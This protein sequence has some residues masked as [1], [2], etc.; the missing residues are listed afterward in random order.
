MPTVDKKHF[1][2]TKKGI[3]KAKDY[4]KKTGKKLETQYEGVFSNIA[5][6]KSEIKR[7]KLEYEKA[8]SEY[9]A[10]MAGQGR[11]SEYAAARKVKQ[12]WLSVKEV[13]K[14]MAVA[15]KPL[16][17]MVEQ[18]VV[19]TEATWEYSYELESD[20][21]DDGDYDTFY[22]TVNAFS[23]RD[24]ERKAEVI[25]NKEKDRINKKLE[26]SRKPGL[27]KLQWVDVVKESLDEVGISALHKHIKSG[28][29]IEQIAKL[30]RLS[31]QTVK[32]LTKG[33][34]KNSTEQVK[35]YAGTWT[36]AYDE[37]QERAKKVDEEVLKEFTDAH[38]ATLKK[39]YEPFRGKSISVS[40]ANKLKNVFERIPDAVLK[41]LKDADIPFLSSM[42]L[43]KM[44][45]KGMPTRE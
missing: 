35:R 10:I 31:V 11:G 13:E 21:R 22:G 42:A 29:T 16:E 24:A 39:E 14:D 20:H 1:K 32:N 2:Y 9:N 40:A 17:G 12:L 5:T 38:I 36:K 25:A 33:L 43:T 3:E 44:I 45:L 30:M 23:E 4:A 18:K 28:K 8:K 34:L 15:L 7:M 26:R 19:V 37:V 6:L 41:K 27:L